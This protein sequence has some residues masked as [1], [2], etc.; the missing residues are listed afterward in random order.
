MTPVAVPTINNNDTDALL[1]RWLV[2]DGAPVEPGTIIAALETSKAGF[3]L[4]AGSAGFLRHAAEP[5]KRYDY[6][7]VIA[8]IADAADATAAVAV[9]QPSPPSVPAGLVITRAAR[10]LIEKHAIPN[11]ALVALGKRIIKAVDLAPLAGAPAAAAPAGEPLPAAQQGVARVVSR[12][13]R[14][15]PASFLLKRADVTAALDR[16]AAASAEAGTVIGLPDLLVHA[17]ASLWEKYPRFFGVLS[18]DLRFTPSERA[19]IG[20][21]FDLGSGLFIPVLR[22]A[23]ALALPEIARRMM[24]LR[25]RAMRN[26]FAA[27]ELEGGS[28]TLSINTGTDLVAVVPIILP[29]QTCMVSLAAVIPTFLPNLDGHPVLRK[30]VHIGIAFDHRAINGHDANAFLDALIAALG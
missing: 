13:H 2:P 21:T 5:G 8:H 1:V 23:G 30:V 9:P 19:D 26:R 7:T 3:D 22:D 27:D 15:I 24:A 18:A 11:S 12:S 17:L 4:E 25:V 10:A 29:P 28:I 6:G 16:L 14:E 20:V